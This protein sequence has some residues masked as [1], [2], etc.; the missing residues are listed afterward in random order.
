MGVGVR[1]TNVLSIDRHMIDQR[2]LLDNEL[3]WN[4]IIHPSVDL[5]KLFL[6]LPWFLWFSDIS[7]SK[8]RQL[9]DETTSG[10]QDIGRN[11]LLPCET[12]LVGTAWQHWNC[13][14]P[15]ELPRFWWLAAQTALGFHPYWVYDLN[16]TPNTGEISGRIDEIG[17]PCL[18]C[19]P[20]VVEQEWSSLSWIWSGDVSSSC[21]S[22]R[23]L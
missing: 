14:I 12:L 19:R 18:P 5:K 4:S 21:T 2:T 16:H 20:G 15:G 22:H 10:E 6:N 7:N 8:T 3:C 13:S 11:N 23:M 17:W 1:P 9:S